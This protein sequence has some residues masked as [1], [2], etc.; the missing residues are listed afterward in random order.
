MSGQPEI[1]VI[2]PVYNGE[3]FLRRA[4][5]SVLKNGFADFELLLLDDGSS[6]GSAAILSEYAEKYPGR[7]RVFSHPNMGVA[8]TRNKGIELANG[9]YLLFLDQDDWF[10]QGYM[11]TFYSAIESSGCDVVYGGYKRPD[12]SGR[13][14]KKRLLSGK[15]YYPYIAIMAWAKIH[16]TAFLKENNIVFF[17]NNIGEDVVF[18][19]REASLTGKTAFLPYTGYNWYLNTDSVSESTHKG[20][21]DDVNILPWMEKVMEFCFETEQLK[22]YCLT[23][24]VIYY[25]LHSGRRSSAKRFMAAYQELFGW[26]GERFPGLTH[27]HYLQWGLPGETTGVRFP[28]S[29]FTALHRFGMIGV[30]ARLYCCGRP[31]QDPEQ[32]R[33]N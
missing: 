13:I 26:L 25:L 19:M 29:V 24:I 33:K 17:D 23:K 12:A 8:R 7:I 9:R 15:G 28:V 2:I 1:S 14:V 6:D 27:N 22:E 21:R 30:F 3:R 32:E 5:C 16:R 10:D 31:E 4:A 18:C 11:Q 20:L